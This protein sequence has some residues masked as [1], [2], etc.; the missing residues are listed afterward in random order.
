MDLKNFD[1]PTATGADMAFPVFK[2]IPELL[3]E[4]KERGFYCGNT[5]YNEL[6]SK[7]F[8]SGG[9]IEFKEDVNEEFKTKAWPYCRAFMGSFEPKH[10]EKE[11]ICAMLMS[12]I[13]KV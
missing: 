13:L 11:A 10:E 12:E 7:L 5:P 1:F 6:F 9:S 8:F 2:T 4:A 3:E